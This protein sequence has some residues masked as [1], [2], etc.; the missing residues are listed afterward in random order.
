MATNPKVNKAIQSVL[1]IIQSL[2]EKNYKNLEKE[3]YLDSMDDSIFTTGNSQI[4]DV[5]KKIELSILLLPPMNFRK[6][7]K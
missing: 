3:Y 5:L 7:K 1:K 6:V 4:Q 2:V